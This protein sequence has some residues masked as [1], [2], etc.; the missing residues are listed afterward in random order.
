M[1]YSLFALTKLNAQIFRSSW[2]K[3]ETTKKN[4]EVFF[5]DDEQEQPEESPHKQQSTQPIRPRKRKSAEMYKPEDLKKQLKKK[6]TSKKD[7]RDDKDEDVYEVDKILDDREVKK[8]GKGVRIEYK[9]KWTDFSEEEWID[10][11]NLSANSKLREYFIEKFRKE[12]Q[13]EEQVEREPEPCNAIIVT[14]DVKDRQLEAMK[15]VIADL[16]RRAKLRINDRQQLKEQLAK[17]GI[18]DLSLD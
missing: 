1:I 9:V 13:L 18:I 10:E 16:A 3:T 6:K 15:K 2:L 5:E 11:E 8:K 14:P 7:Q 4:A 12:A 17:H